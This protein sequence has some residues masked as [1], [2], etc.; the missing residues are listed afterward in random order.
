M[1]VEQVPIR[2]GRAQVYALLAGLCVLCA[3]MLC[4][5]QL[6]VPLSLLIPL[7]AC[8]LAGRREEPVAWAAAAMPA[9]SALMADCDP[10]YA[11]SLSLTGVL[12]M[13]ATKLLPAK[14][15]AGFTGILWH[16]GAVAA[17]L[18]A[19]AASA[20]HMLG[21]P[22]WQTL[23]GMIV[24]EVAQGEQAGLVLYR[25]GA[26]GLISMPDMGGPVLMHVLEPELVR[27]MLLSLRLTLETLL[28]ELLPALFVQLSVMVGLFTALRVQRM[29]GVI[30][31]VEAQTSGERKARVAVPPG[32][33]L[34]AMPAGMHLPM[35][36]IAVLALVLMLSEGAVAQMVGQMCYTL[37]ETAFML[38]G[39]A[40]VVFVFSNRHPERKTLFGVLAAALYVMVPFMLFLIGL[41]DQTFHYR[42]KRS[43]SPD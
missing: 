26:A 39:A 37:F 2:P 20:S 17:G 22:L 25:L 28:F 5:P 23:A 3:A 41:T 13:L 40:V 9:L 34:L 36:L 21:G 15:R 32:F 35:T 14:K 31:V 1:A 29:N 38:V 19:I 33:R 4:L 30:L 16:M 43:G 7:F 6:C 10:I 24:Q 8:P 11:V 12:S 42:L 18:T 27:Q